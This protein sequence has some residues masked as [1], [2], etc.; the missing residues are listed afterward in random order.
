MHYRLPCST[1]I[2]QEEGSKDATK[3]WQLWEAHISIF[4]A[5]LITPCG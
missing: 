4:L 3:K 5:S 1:H 2:L